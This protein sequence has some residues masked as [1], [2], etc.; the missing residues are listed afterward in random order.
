MPGMNGNQLAGVLSNRSPGIAVLYMSGYP[1]DIISHRGI[2]SPDV[3][4]IEKS[5]LARNLCYRVRALL[6]SR[7][8]PAIEAAVSSLS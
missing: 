4:L 8:H 5:H 6:D 2:L 7:S 1:Q 3:S